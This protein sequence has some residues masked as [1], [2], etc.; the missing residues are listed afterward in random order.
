MPIAKAEMVD[1]GF[2][3]G[4]VQVLRMSVCVEEQFKRPVADHLA[5]GDA[6]IR[7]ANNPCH[8]DVITLRVGAS[9]FTVS[10]PTTQD[11][12]HPNCTLDT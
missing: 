1:R 6:P 4:C 9:D 7:K 8:R 2:I 10:T 3:A 11:D 12:T 5:F